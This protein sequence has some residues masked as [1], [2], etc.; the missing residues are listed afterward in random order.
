MAGRLIH[1]ACGG[2]ITN[3]ADADTQECTRCGERWAE[4]EG[5]G[6]VAGAWCV[7]CCATSGLARDELGAI[8]CAG[9]RDCHPR[10]GRYGFSGGGRGAAIAGPGKNR[11][12][13]AA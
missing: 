6:M 9:C 10:S 1:T 11:G 2:T 8:E 4:V 7:I 13:G 5:E 3:G 12:A